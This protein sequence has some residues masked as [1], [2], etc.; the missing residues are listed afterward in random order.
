[1]VTGIEVIFPTI[2]IKNQCDIEKRNSI[3]QETL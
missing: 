1:M 2:I 3:L